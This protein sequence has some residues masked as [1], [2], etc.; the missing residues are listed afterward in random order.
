MSW[1]IETNFQNFDRIKVTITGDQILPESAI[2]ICNHQSLADYV[3]MVYLARSCGTV[4]PQ[5]NFFAWFSLWRVPTIKTL[6]NIFKCDENWELSPQLAEAI[7]RRAVISEAPEWVVLFPEVNIIT[8]TTLYFQNL[9]SERYYLP[10]FTNVLYPRFSGLY[11]AAVAINI[12]TS[13]KFTR[14][15]DVT[16]NYDH[17][18]SLLALFSSSKR[19]QV[20]IHVKAKSLTHLPQKRSKMEKWLEK[21][22]VEKEKQVG[23]M[24]FDKRASTEESS[25]VLDIPLTSLASSLPNHLASS[26]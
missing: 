26:V 10:R 9:Q 13:M 11:N 17:P 5:T 1:S 6:V 18:M 2:V 8:P 15:Y 7:F 23:L 21:A 22:W 16:L 25:L 19:F 14:L 12:A 24:E 3:F 20:R 4:H